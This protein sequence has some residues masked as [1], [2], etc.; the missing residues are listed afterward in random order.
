MIDKSDT[1][2]DNLVVN[3]KDRRVQIW[4]RNGLSFMLNDSKTMIQKLTYIHNN[5]VQD[6]WALSNNTED[7]FYSTARYYKTE[8]DNFGMLSNISSI[9]W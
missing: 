1:I 5:P 9:L 8:F 6:K 7:Y 2:L 3:A 4:E